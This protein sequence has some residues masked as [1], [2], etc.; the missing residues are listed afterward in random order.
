M[1]NLSWSGKF[2]F[3]S[4]DQY[5]KTVEFLHMVIG[6]T[7]SLTRLL[8][9]CYTSLSKVISQ[10]WSAQCRRAVSRSFPRF[11]SLTLYPLFSTSMTDLGLT[12]FKFARNHS[13]RYVIHSFSVFVLWL[14]FWALWL[15]AKM[16][17]R[18]LFLPFYSI[19]FDLVCENACLTYCCILF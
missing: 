10:V 19:F 18:A 11:P 4:H 17:K 7:Y 6:N 9:F 8:I 3:P 16:G 13:F 14:W 12:I 2:V 15:G 5:M 1:K